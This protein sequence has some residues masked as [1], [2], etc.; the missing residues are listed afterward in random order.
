MPD[1]TISDSRLL[2]KEARANE[3]RALYA[4]YPTILTVGALS[5][6]QTKHTPSA[7][8]LVG[9]YG[10]LVSS[11][12]AFLGSFQE[13][14]LGPN[15]V[16]GV[17]GDAVSVKQRAMRLEDTPLGR[18]IDIDVYDAASDRPISRSTLRKC[19]L[20]DR[21]A[22]VCRKEGTHSSEAL[23]EAIASTIVREDLVLIQ[24]L[25][26]KAVDAELDLD[27]KFGLV[28][29]K[30]G[31]SH[32][33]MSIELMRKS[34]HA[35]V[36]YLAE[37]FF[38]PLWE[39]SLSEL[40]HSARK[41]GLVAEQAMY[42]ATNGVNTHKGMI[43]NLGLA[44]LAAGCLVTRRLPWSQY[45]AL[46]EA[47]AAPLTDEIGK[48]SSTAGQEI[49]KRYPTMGARTEAIHGFPA[50][51]RVIEH[52][53]D[54]AW[55]TKMTV[56]VELVKHTEDTVLFKRAGSIER[57]QEVKSWFEALDPKD[58][59]AVSALSQACVKEKLSFGG[60]A[61]LFVV[62]SFLRLIQVHFQLPT[63]KENPND[64]I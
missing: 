44:V 51:R 55:E 46:V 9:R 61:D 1:N 28:T 37:L 43:F 64:R 47:L 40:F 18:L 29:P 11:F 20:C 10:V 39:E 35:V 4:A 8:Y 25:L 27:P 17:R 16:F 48:D 7:R 19:L 26:H 34:K 14:I 50:V 45:F 60:A 2:A 31:G 58:S 5:P 21:P 42:R 63:D 33:D 62:A 32:P 13:D 12:G 6:G 24:Q 38:L 49:A 36:P 3:I 23:S 52:Y 57:Y 15:Y 59:K 30:T 56:F 22:A 41:I 53:V 54:D